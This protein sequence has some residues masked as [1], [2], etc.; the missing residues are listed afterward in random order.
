MRAEIQ[1]LRFVAA[2]DADAVG[3]QVIHVEIPGLI[4][5]RC[6]AARIAHPA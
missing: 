2:E 3:E 6:R 4:E 5:G 1:V